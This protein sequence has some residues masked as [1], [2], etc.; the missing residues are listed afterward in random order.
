MELWRQELYHY[1]V[2]HLNGGHSGRYPWGSKNNETKNGSLFVSGSSKTQDKGS[3]YYRRKLP[4]GVRSELDSAMDSKKKILVGDAPGID[5]Q[6]QDYLKKKKYDNVEVYGPGPEKPRYIANDKWRTNLVVNKNAEPGSKEWLAAKDIAM[7]NNAT[8]GLAVILDAGANA[9]R[10]NIARLMDQ[11][12]SVS[13]YE[14]SQNGKKYDTKIE[15]GKAIVE[16]VLGP[17]ERGK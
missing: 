2:G 17:K 1:G 10:R 11:N 6:V 15:A 5:R 13:V 7:T 14:L 16:A 12:K 3:G 9:T 8:E 4:K